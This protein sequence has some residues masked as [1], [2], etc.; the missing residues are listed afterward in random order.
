MRT[1]SPAGREL[2]QVRLADELTVT[3][4][5]TP[6]SIGEAQYLY[7][8]IFTHDDYLGQLLPLRPGSVV[9]D[10]GANIGLFSLRVA[11][12]C[13]NARVFSFEPVPDVCALLRRNL[14]DAGFADAQVHQVALGARTGSAALTYFRQLSA[15]STAHPE[16]KPTEWT[17]SMRALEPERADEILATEQVEVDVARLSDLW[18][19]DAPTI[20][21]LKIDVEGAELD[22]LHGIDNRHWPTIARIVAEVQD[23]G[24]RLDEVLEL[25]HRR[26]FVTDVRQPAMMSPEMGCRIVTARRAQRGEPGVA[27]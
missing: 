17:A 6:W 24:G 2:T 1:Y 21:L 3:T 19:A 26:G 14:S 8:E 7:D 11:R 27:H 18:P 13:P 15:N 5:D 22:V 25:L 4:F 16:E 9:I 20:D 23:V 10:A 12:S